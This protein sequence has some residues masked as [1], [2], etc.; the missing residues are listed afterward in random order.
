MMLEQSEVN[1]LLYALR[2]L[3][4]SCSHASCKCMADALRCC[5]Y[6]EGY[7]LEPAEVREAIKLLDKNGDGVGPAVGCQMCWLHV[8]Q[9]RPAAGLISFPEFVE[10]WQKEVRVVAA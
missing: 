7:D 6:S 1:R 10:W 4:P 9:L 2:K 5:S 8:T 3:L